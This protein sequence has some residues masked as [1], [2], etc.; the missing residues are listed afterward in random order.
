MLRRTSRAP[1]GSFREQA[2]IREP[3]GALGGAF[4]GAKVEPGAILAHGGDEALAGP[5]CVDEAHPSL[6]A[7]NDLR[8]P[9]KGANG[10]RAVITRKNVIDF[11]T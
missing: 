9:G 4:R 10:E 7:V 2:P 3:R 6:S 5:P 8:H 11:G 1:W